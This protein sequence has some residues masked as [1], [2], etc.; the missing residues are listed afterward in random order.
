MKLM[1]N[2]PPSEEAATEWGWGAAQPSN[3]N[4]VCDA[5]TLHNRRG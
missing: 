2:V 3:A 5:T 1:T 4:E